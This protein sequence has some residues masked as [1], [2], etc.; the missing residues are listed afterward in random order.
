MLNKISTSSKK[1]IK[2]WMDR[3][4]FNCPTN[5][6]LNRKKIIKKT[7]KFRNNLSIINKLLMEFGMLRVLSK[8]GIPS[9]QKIT[10]SM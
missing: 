9:V 5:T 10:D 3:F 2:L 4:Y 8:I 6:L 7:N 1:S